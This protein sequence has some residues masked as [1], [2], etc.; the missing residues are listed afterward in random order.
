MKSV[1]PLPVSTLNRPSARLRWVELRTNHN[2][3]DVDRGQAGLDELRVL[4]VYCRCEYRDVT[5]LK[6]SGRNMRI[7]CVIEYHI[8]HMTRRPYGTA[9]P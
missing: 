4:I 5:A 1:Q 8:H 7:V 9:D 2:G 3:R 6:T